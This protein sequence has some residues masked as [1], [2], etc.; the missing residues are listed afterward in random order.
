[1]L[2]W[3]PV[4]GVPLLDRWREPP[5]PLAS[6]L[7]IRVLDN[8]WMNGLLKCCEMFLEGCYWYLWINN[9]IFVNVHNN[10]KPTDCR[11]LNSTQFSLIIAQHFSFL[12]LAKEV[13]SMLPM[14]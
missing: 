1:M 4:Q 13:I 9:V 11:S 14:T 10:E 5:A 2:T 8:D 7:G 12:P 6:P 3:Q